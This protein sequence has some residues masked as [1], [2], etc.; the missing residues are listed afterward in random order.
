[1]YKYHSE[2]PPTRRAA[3]AYRGEPCR[4]SVPSVASTHFPPGEVVKARWLKYRC[5]PMDTPTSESTESGCK[6]R[7]R[8]RKTLPGTAW[9]VYDTF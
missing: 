8:A 5:I 9:N 3:A 2:T 4:E 1:M 6:T 7:S